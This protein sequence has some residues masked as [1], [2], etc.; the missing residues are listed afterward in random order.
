MDVVLELH[1]GVLLLKN[2]LLAADLV[3]LFGEVL[4]IIVGLPPFLVRLPNVL[5]QGLHE[6]F[7]RDALAIKSQQILT[8]ILIDHHDAMQ[9]LIA[10]TLARMMALSENLDDT[11]A[12][13]LAQM[14]THDELIAIKDQ[15]AFKLLAISMLLFLVL[16]EQAVEYRLR[17]DPVPIHAILDTAKS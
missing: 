15:E 9:D 4:G 5:S 2:L 6:H 17:H 10:H 7:V 16:E 1:L 13:R 14:I 3:F 11:L 12:L 8:L